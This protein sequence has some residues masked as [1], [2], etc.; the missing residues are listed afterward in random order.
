MDWGERF[1]K[2]HNLGIML[3]CRGTNTIKTLLMT[4]NDRDNKLQKSGVI[5]RFKCPHINCLK[6]YIGESGRSFREQ[7]KEHLGPHYL[8]TN[9]VTP[10]DTQ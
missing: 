8:Y 2:T 6:E 7:L 3:H 4:L 1:E 10:Q 9:T 5:Y